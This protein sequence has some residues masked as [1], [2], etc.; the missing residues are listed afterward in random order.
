MAAAARLLLRHWC[1]PQLQLPGAALHMMLP[2]KASPPVSN[3]HHRA[4][5]PSWLAWAMASLWAAVGRCSMLLAAVVGIRGPKR[6]H[7]SFGRCRL[8]R[9]GL[10]GSLPLEPPITH[11]H[12]CGGRAAAVPKG[13][14]PLQSREPAGWHAYPVPR[15]LGPLATMVA[16]CCAGI[17]VGSI[18]G[19]YAPSEECKIEDMDDP[20][21]CSLFQLFLAQRKAG[22]GADC[23][24]SKVAGGL[25]P[26]GGGGTAAGGRGSSRGPRQR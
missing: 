25:M 22:D 24:V 4:P 17:S 16:L 2:L 1:P 26:T 3:D 14:A 7:V 19:I 11:Q 13:T 21:A 20:G 23:M 8:H 10:P 15:T 9:P 6:G 5:S 18:Y 12:G